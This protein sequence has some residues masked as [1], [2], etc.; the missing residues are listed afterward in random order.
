MKAVIILPKGKM[1]KKDIKRL[2]DNLFCVVEC[3]DPSLVRFMEPP[4]LGYSA[5]EQAAIK[6]CRY[7]MDRQT[8][9]YPIGRQAIASL[10]AEFLIEG[11]P[12]EAIQPVAAVEGIK[13]NRPQAKPA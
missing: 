8:G 1:S 7:L 4:P 6:L 11:S 13:A 3:D 5:Q 10:L 2:N 12:L 9:G